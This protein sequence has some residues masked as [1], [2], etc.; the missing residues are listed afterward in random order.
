MSGPPGIIIDPRAC[1]ACR[2]CELACHFHH[3]RTFGTSDRSVRIDYDPD[4]GEVSIV[5]LD[6]CDACVEEDMPLCVQFCTP[7]AL[8]LRS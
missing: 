4:R 2:A 3:T 7:A 8:T 6:T 1:T 5:F